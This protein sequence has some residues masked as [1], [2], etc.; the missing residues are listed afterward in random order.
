MLPRS[1]P[2]TTRRLNYGDIVL[3]EPALLKL[4]DELI[5]QIDRALGG[6]AR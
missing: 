6:P 3:L 4:Y 2:K 5:P 1:P